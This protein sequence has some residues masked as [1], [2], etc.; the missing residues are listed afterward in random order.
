MENTT[1]MSFATSVFTCVPAHHAFSD[2]QETPRSL[3][4]R[5]GHGQGHLTVVGERERELTS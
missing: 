1:P 2:T 3:D 5:E 4:K